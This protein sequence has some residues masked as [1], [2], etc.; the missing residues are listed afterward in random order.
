MK[1]LITTQVVDKESPSLGFFHRWVEEFAKHCESVEVICLYEGTHSLPD[2]VHVHSLGKEQKEKSVFSTFFYTIRFTFLIFTLRNK[3]DSVF[4]HMNPEYIVLGG[5]FWKVWK[6]KIGLWYLHRS[7]TLRLRIAEF[8]ADVI[9]SASP[10]S[11]RLKSNKLRIV[12]HGINLSQFNHPLH[13]SQDEL[14]V[15]TTG[16]IAPSKRLVEMLEVFDILNARSIP[17]TFTIVGAPATPADKEYQEKVTAEI[18]KRPYHEKVHFVGAVSHDRIGRLLDQA[19]VFLNL[20]TTGSTDKAVLE[21]FAAGMPAVTSNEAFKTLLEPIGLYVSSA[22]F[23]KIA[24]ALEKAVGTDA[25]PLRSYVAM[26]HSLEA[27][28]PRILTAL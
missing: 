25:A 12:G 14:K 4:V 28:I 27:L 19:N 22:D 26:N 2:N 7:V 5:I 18:R 16:R 24:D 11:F 17:F 3:Y 23:A 9:F 1:L 8:L 15:I 6:K 13:G 20:S 21:A 10:E